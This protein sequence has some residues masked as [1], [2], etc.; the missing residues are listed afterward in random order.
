MKEPRKI[1]TT[2][3]KSFM[4][5]MLE[6]KI[7]HGRLLDKKLARQEKQIKFLAKKLG[8]KLT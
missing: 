8:V 6:I 1:T 5:K 2:D 3:D 4:L 7:A